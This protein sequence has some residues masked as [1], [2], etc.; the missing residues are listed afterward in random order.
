MKYIDIDNHKNTFSSSQATLSLPKKTKKILN[1]TLYWSAIYSFSRGTK[2]LKGNSFVYEG[3]GQRDSTINKIKFKTPNGT[4]HNIDGTIILDKF[5][6]LNYQDNSP[7]VCYADVTDIINKSK[8]QNGAYTVADIK[9]TQD[10]T[11]GGSAGGWLLYVVFETATDKPK[12]I[13]TFHGLVTVHKNALDVELKDF[14]TVKNGIAKA[15]LALSALE[16]DRSLGNDQ[17]LIYNKTKEIFI[18]LEN[19]LRSGKNFFNST[20]TINDK[21]FK[22]RLPN[23]VN[24]LGFD[25]AE[26]DIPNKNNEL[27]SNEETSLTLRLKTKSDR[28]HLFFAAFKTELEGEFYKNKKVELAGQKNN[29][30]YCSKHCR[31]N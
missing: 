25:I 7:Y 10:F 27:I 12:Y 1:A 21:V 17:C 24:T 9:A 26:M 23:S 8:N 14:K 6:P 29:S 11:T 18:P 3:N 5:N 16:G 22:D 28:F 13:S 30:K 15:S 19:K 31:F 4:Y 20:I 2:K